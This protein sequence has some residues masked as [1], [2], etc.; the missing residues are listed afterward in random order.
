MLRLDNQPYRLTTWLFFRA[1]PLLE[2]ALVLVR[3]DHVTSSI[4][5]AN[6]DAI[7]NPTA[8]VALEPPIRARG[9]LP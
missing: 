8:F 3:L 2:L 6:H 1:S 9:E 5:N 7:E 4:V